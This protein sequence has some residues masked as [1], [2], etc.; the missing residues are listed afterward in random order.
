MYNETLYITSCDQKKGA[1][2]PKTYWSWT[3]TYCFLDVVIS[4]VLLLA[5]KST[6][7]LT[8]SSLTIKRT[9]AAKTLCTI[10]VPIP[11]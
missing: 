11:L 2:L 4:I 5:T 6:A 9:E 7:N 1:F 8:N 3:N 10:F